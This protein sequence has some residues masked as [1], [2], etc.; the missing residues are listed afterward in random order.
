MNEIANVSSDNFFLN[1]AKIPDVAY[2]L[3]FYSR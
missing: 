1:L 3:Q 2:M